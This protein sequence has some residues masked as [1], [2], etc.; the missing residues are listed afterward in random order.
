VTS[1]D[2]RRRG[3]L[4][5]APRY[6]YPA[7]LAIDGRPARGRDISHSGL[8][9]YIDEPLPIGRT[10]GVTLGSVADGAP[11]LSAPARVVRCVPEG[12]RH[13]VGVEFLRDAWVWALG[14]RPERN[15]A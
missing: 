8:S 5:A 15:G 2:R 9:A 13:V 1:R 10:V 4:P 11:A 12:Q 6:P 14:Q 3:P 7:H